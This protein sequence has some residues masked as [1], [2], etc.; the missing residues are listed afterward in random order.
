MQGVPLRIIPQMQS[1]IKEQPKGCK[2]VDFQ[3]TRFVGIEWQCARPF[4]VVRACA[5]A[6]CTSTYVQIHEV[7]A[8]GVPQS[9]LARGLH[10]LLPP[11]EVV[12][13]SYCNA[14]PEQPREWEARPVAA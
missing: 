13:Q 8:W 3:G 14:D 10:A 1:C 7:R 12:K 11:I 5:A 2:E 4:C 9:V 6:C